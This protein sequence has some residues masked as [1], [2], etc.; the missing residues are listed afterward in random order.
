M[1]T[2]DSTDHSIGRE[3]ET[4][5]I[6]PNRTMSFI[7]GLTKTNDAWPLTTEAFRRGMRNGTASGK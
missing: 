5:R 2:L 1:E 3:D 6:L 4:L 7:L